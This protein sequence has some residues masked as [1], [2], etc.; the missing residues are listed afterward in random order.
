[1]TLL[2]IDKNRAKNC[3]NRII[4]C[5]NLNFFEKWNT[6]VNNQVDARVVFDKLFDKIDM[7]RLIISWIISKCD[8]LLIV[9][10]FQFFVHLIVWMKIWWAEWEN[11]TKINGQ[12]LIRYLKKYCVG[13]IQHH[14][15]TYNWKVFENKFLLAWQPHGVLKNKYLLNHM[16]SKFW[17]SEKNTY[18]QACR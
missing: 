12:I 8:F 13:L 17:F 2:M 1:M 3:V 9:I 15:I 7:D 5:K 14:Y 6:W 11:P 16:A 10:G 18:I 4:F